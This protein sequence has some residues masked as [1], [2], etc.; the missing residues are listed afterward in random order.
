MVLCF[1]AWSYDPT[2]GSWTSS[3]ASRRAFYDLNSPLVGQFNPAG[4]S[5]AA[6]AVISNQLFGAGAG[7]IRSL[8]LPSGPVV[9]EL[10]REGP[11]EVS[12]MAFDS[13]AN[14]LIIIGDGAIWSFDLVNRE[15][16]RRLTVPAAGP[17][18]GGMY[19]RSAAAAYDE[20]SGLVVIFD[21]ERTW[22]FD[23]D[24]GELRSYP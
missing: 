16:L 24:S 10:D 12:A 22:T 4:T 11:A 8:E 23:H 5:R 18:T 21:G 14:V 9:A 1:G 2:D 17:S 6:T 7:Q 13:R 3:P 19:W 15:L 20:E